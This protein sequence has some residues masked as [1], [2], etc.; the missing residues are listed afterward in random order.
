MLLVFL[1]AICWVAVLVAMVGGYVIGRLV[2]YQD[3]WDDR[4]DEQRAV[5]ADRARHQVTVIEGRVR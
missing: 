3:G 2:G 4:G 1:V 5:A